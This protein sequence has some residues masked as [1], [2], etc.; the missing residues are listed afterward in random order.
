MNDIE[1]LSSCS[2]RSACV[3]SLGRLR[4]NVFSRA[5]VDEINRRVVPLGGV[6]K[7]VWAKLAEPL[8]SK[9]AMLLDNLQEMPPPIHLPAISFC[10]FPL[11][12][13]VQRELAECLKVLENSEVIRLPRII[14]DEARRREIKRRAA[15][16]VPKVA[17]FPLGAEQQWETYLLVEKFAKSPKKLCS[18]N[19]NALAAWKHLAAKSYA[20]FHGSRLS[21]NGLKKAEK[22]LSKQ[23]L[24]F[25][26]RIS[27]I[28]N[29]IK[30][31]YPS[32]VVF[33]SQTKSS[34]EP[35]C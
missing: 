1:T 31:V 19:S 23:K 30:N 25:E 3:A 16:S 2:T 14:L 35:S 5:V 15:N 32:F 20:S 33:G 7:V 18:D 11:S 26:K 28:G 34:G 4:H 17:L 13:E 6:E 27:T 10:G 8:Q 12:A 22:V 21:V 9:I 24:E 29:A